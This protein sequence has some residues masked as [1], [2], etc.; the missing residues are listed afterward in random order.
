MSSEESVLFSVEGLT[1]KELK[2]RQIG[3]LLSLSWC[4][5]NRL[6]VIDHQIKSL[7]DDKKLLLKEKDKLNERLKEE[8]K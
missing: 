4:L 8:K 3:E 6:L 1:E 5:E 2:Q 7:E